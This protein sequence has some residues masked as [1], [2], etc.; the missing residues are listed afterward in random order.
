MFEP[1]LSV[2]YVLLLVL[3][4]SVCPTQHESC[5]KD[6]T[7]R[8]VYFTFGAF[9]CTARGHSRQGPPC[10]FDVERMRRLAIRD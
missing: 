7:V 5:E 10:S 2:P 8:G 1:H 6:G 4:V 3:A 9:L